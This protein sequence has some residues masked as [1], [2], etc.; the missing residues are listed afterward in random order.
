MKFGREIWPFAASFTVCKTRCQVKGATYGKVDLACS[1]VWELR[2][3]THRSGAERGL[4]G[5][6]ELES[7]G[8][9]KEN[10]ILQ[11]QGIAL[12]RLRQEDCCEFEVRLG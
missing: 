11:L 10:A 7:G 3:V 5:A 9:G 12:E 4:A 6:R 8:I 1:R 2:Y